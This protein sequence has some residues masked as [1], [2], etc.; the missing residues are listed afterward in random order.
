MSAPTENALRLPVRITQRTSSLSLAACSNS[1]SDSS[2][3]LLNAFS[4][5]GL[6]S[7]SSRTHG[8]LIFHF[9]KSEGELSDAAN[10]ADIGVFQILRLKLRPPIKIHIL[11]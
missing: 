2:S 10:E 1:A 9:T 11:E 8:S 7:S 5:S 3:V 6:F 4:F